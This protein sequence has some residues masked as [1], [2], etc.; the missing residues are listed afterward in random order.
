MIKQ[1]IPAMLAATALSPLAAGAAIAQDAA[2]AEAATDEGDIVVTA[3][4]RAE[5]LQDVPDSIVAFGAKDIAAAGIDQIQDIADMVPNMILRKGFRSG[6][7]NITIRGI[8]SGR[9]GWPPVAFVIDGVKATSIDAMEQGTLL[10]VER[11]EVLKGPQGAL[12]GAGA[13]GG[14]IN[15]VTR[16]PGF[17]FGGYVRAEYAIDPNGP[18]V[19]GALDIPL[20]EN[21]AVRVVG[22]YSDVDGYI[23]NSFSKKDQPARREIVGRAVLYYDNGGPVTMTAKYEHADVDVDGSPVQ[24]MSALKGRGIDHVKESGLAFSNEFD[25]IRTDTASL[26]FDIEIGDHVL[27]T[28]TGYSH[29]VNKNR[30]DADFTEVTGASAD[31]DMNFNQMSQEVRLLSPTGKTIEYVVGAYYQV[32][33]LLEQRTTGV[34]FA[35]AA[36]T[37]RVMDQDSRVWSFYGQLT[38]NITGS[39]RAIGAVRYTH[40]RKSA[41]YK[42]FSGPNTYTDQRTGTQVANFS[43]RLREGLIDPSATIQYDVG[44]NAMVYLTYSRGS[45]GGGFQG[46]ISNAEPFSFQFDPERSESFEAG[47]KLSFPGV[48]HLNLAAYRTKYTNLQVSAA[49]PSPD[50]LSAPFFTGNAGDAV[51]KGVELDGLV[52]LGGG[53]ELVGNAAWTPSAKYGEYGA[54]PCYTGQTPDGTQPGSCDLSGLRLNFTP[55]WAGAVTARYSG[56]IGSALKFTGSLTTLFQ[57]FSRRDSTRDPLAVQPAYAKIDAR[58]GIGAPDDRWELAVIGRNL[59]DKTTVA[60]VGAGGLAATVFSPDSRSL[61]VDAPR[62]FAVQALYK[63]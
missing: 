44:D 53:F 50:G 26:Q 52:R 57:S 41:T 43:D 3:R 4:L 38:A 27:T 61:T 59:T 35:P 10:D 2:R 19:E 23:Y 62:T 29:F 11:I 17:E 28:I 39:L 1:M 45:K 25:N 18:T 7:S 21:L 31:F 24:I 12:Y 63:F 42:R 49:L 13:I 16:K 6:E 37:Y 47:A 54:G 14:A 55:K 9:Q 22:K 58:I 51:V 48:G 56:D 32:G 60:F 33:D 15:I 40:E 8:T 20:A 46:A 5:S 30:I 34:L 36:S